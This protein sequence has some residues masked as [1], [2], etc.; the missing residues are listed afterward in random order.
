MLTLDS[1]S[2]SYRGPAG[3]VPVLREVDLQFSPGDLA[4]ING[5][6][7]CGK[8]TLLF[9]AGAMMPPDRGAVQL[10]GRSLYQ[11][12]RARRH[13]VRGTSVGFIFQRFHLVPYLSVED[14]ILWP[15]RWSENPAQAARGLPALARRLLIGDRLQHRPAQLSAG[16]QQRA[17]VARALIGQKSLICADEPTGNLDD[18]NA[19]IV[20][21]ILKEEAARGAIVLL[22]THQRNLVG[23][24]NVHIEWMADGP[25]VRKREDATPSDGRSRSAAG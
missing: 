5:P 16:E 9:T 23:L 20:D 25:V 4:V 14:N 11:L 7:G 2:K 18:D 3:P 17:A 24:G 21:E 15:L 12:S 8:S 22:V 6:S 19:V 13:Q 1:V 10:A